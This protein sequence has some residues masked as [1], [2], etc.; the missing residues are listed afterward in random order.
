MDYKN[1][2]NLPK[3]SFP[4]KANLVKREPLIL[5]KWEK[6]NLYRRMLD[7]NKGG[8]PFI[9]HDGP[10]YANGHIHMGTALNKILKDI[11]IKS[12]NM[13][14]YYTPY[15]PGWDCHGLP[16]EFQVEKEVG[17]KKEEL[18]VVEF[19]K[20]CRDF[21]NKFI[22]IQ[23]KE[24][25][26]LGVLGDWENP[27][28][29]MDYEYEAD[30]VREF[31]KFAK[32]GYVY[33]GEKPVYWCPR[34]ETALAEAEVEY[35]EKKS[36]SIYVKF[37]FKDD[38]G[39]R[40]KE[41]KGKKASVLIWT[42]TPWTIPA[43]L[44]VCLHPE[45][46]YVAFQKGDEVFIVSEY[47][48]PILKEELSWKDGEI[49]AKFQ[50]KDLEGMKLKHPLYER[51]SVIILGEHVT[52][53]AGTGC[54]HTAPG[55]G[56][57]DY[58][59]G[60]KYNLPIYAPVDEKGRFTEDVEFFS[61]MNVF[62][63]NPEVERKLQELGMLVKREEVTHSYPHCWRCKGPVIFRATKQWFISIDKNNLR[64][65]LL[66][67]IDKNVKW[68][69]E[70]G[71]NRIYS[72]MEKRPDWCIS[73]QRFWG[74]PIVAF[75]CKKCGKL[76]LKDELCE[77]VAE[78]FEK[79]GADA[80]F[81]MDEEKLMP[82]GYMCDCGSREFVRERDIL[83]VWFDSGVSFAAVIIKRKL[84][85]PVDMYLEGSDQHRGWFH[86]SLICSV[87]TRNTPPY[88]SVLTHGFVVDGQGRKMS[89]SLGNVIY[90]NEIVEKYGA[91]I[92]RLWVA[93]E[94][95]RDDIRISKEILERNIEVYRRIRNSIRFMLGN[96]FDFDPEK[97]RIPL[98][99][100]FEIDRWILARTEKL[101]RRIKKAYREYRFH[102]VYHEIHN[103]C[104][105]D[106]SSIYL[107]IL[108]DRLYIYP[109]GSVERRSA[110][111]AIYEILKTLLLL[112]SPILSFTS[113]EAWEHLP[114][115]R[116]ESIFLETFPKDTDEFLDEKLLEKWERF[117]E[118]RRAVTKSLEEARRSGTIGH[119]L[120]AKV[121]LTVPEDMFGIFSPW[122][123]ETLSHYL[124]V[125]QVEM[126]KGDTLTVSVEKA[127]GKKCERCWRYGEVDE[128]GL[129]RRCRKIVENLSSTS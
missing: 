36:P 24:F 58:E 74:V 63:A 41:L 68:I 6:M 14:G 128:R 124:I 84:P 120:D 79:Q 69:P 71:R 50:G 15:I 11:I 9:L 119:S 52:L 70:W 118:L 49:L 53:D 28:I 61:G 77:H 92:L 38:P 111:T 5:D 86:S 62:E 39:E 34:C 78:I 66:E 83:D 2:L 112:M 102:I 108:K 45:H 107:D 110:Q 89:K 72:M 47:L 73:R 46:T 30:I 1:T 65:K 100:M 4:M 3:T 17:K 22:D 127:D 37:P 29:T 96:L 7:K 55:H 109:A 32:M 121:K 101:K 67:A 35:Y 13:E 60:L 12:K 42:T 27:Y 114:G 18:D 126:K 104:T 51:D 129:C 99:E 8:T 90:P 95:Y 81:T 115:K 20:K 80:W 54:V 87:A 93:S 16:I 82:N 10:P 19:R 103:F 117:L 43:N 106:L 85:F 97:D 25:K 113:E 125:S 91:E 94:D 21:A 116:T 98:E 88:K 75:W 31:S 26:R 76:H 57:E 48:L 59:V 40:I 123:E 64:K 44:A 122:G 105:V 23:R 33:V 56:D